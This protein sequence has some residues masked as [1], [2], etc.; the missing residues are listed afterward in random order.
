MSRSYTSLPQSATMAC[1]GTVF[2]ADPLGKSSDVACVV[3]VFK[4]SCLSNYYSYFQF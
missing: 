3:N 2:F 1:S 4:L